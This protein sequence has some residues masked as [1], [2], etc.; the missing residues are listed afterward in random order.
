MPSKRE[1]QLEQAIS[2]LLRQ[3]NGNAPQPTREELLDQVTGML[4]TVVSS[5]ETNTY[6]KLHAAGLLL[7]ATKQVNPDS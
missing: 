5:P 6:Q 7:K 4:L 2:G 1:K 3:I